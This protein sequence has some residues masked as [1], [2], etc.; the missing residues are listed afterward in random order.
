MPKPG[1]K[2]QLVISHSCEAKI[3]HLGR[4]RKAKGYNLTNHR[5]AHQS[6]LYDSRERSSQA[7]LC[8]SPFAEQGCTS[9][10]KR[11][12]AVITRNLWR[13]CGNQRDMMSF[14]DFQ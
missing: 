4:K 6:G 9:T 10:V 12:V 5:A 13:L 3:C 14:P 8:V 2:H 11:T 1:T 7:M